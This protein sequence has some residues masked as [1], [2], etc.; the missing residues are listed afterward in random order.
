ME[1]AINLSVLEIIQ[2]IKKNET[3]LKDWENIIPN[4][5]FEEI[6]SCFDFKSKTPWE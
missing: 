3:D 6:K 4:D 5:L 1:S 2:S